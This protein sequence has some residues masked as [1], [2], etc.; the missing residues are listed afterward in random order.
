[1]VLAERVFIALVILVKQVACGI[2]AHISYG[3]REY[4]LRLSALQRHGPELRVPREGAGFR[5]NAYKGAEQHL[6]VRSHAE[7]ILAALESGD[8]CRSAAAYAHSPDVPGALAGGGEHNLISIRS[9]NGIGLIGGAGGDL[10]GKSALRADHKD[11][12]LIAERYPFSVRRDGRLPEPGSIAL[13]L[14]AFFAALWLFCNKH[15][16]LCWSCSS[17]ILRGRQ[18]FG[19]ISHKN[20]SCNAHKNEQSDFYCLF[21]I[22]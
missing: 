13:C 14:S 18:T 21:H 8:A 12:S 5:I 15:N 16:F 9:P 1:M 22:K 6:A 3:E 17:R 20:Q 11:V 10:T 19:H 7:R 4:H 2:H